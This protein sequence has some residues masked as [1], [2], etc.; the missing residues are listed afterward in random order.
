MRTVKAIQADPRVGEEVEI[1]EGRVEEVEPVSSRT[2][3][4]G[5]SQSPRS[6]GVLVADEIVAAKRATSCLLEPAIGDRVLV[7]RHGAEAF[8]LAVLERET[9]EATVRLGS[10]VSL[11]VD[12]RNRVEVV[13]AEELHLNARNVVS[14]SA[15]ELRVRADR[16]GVL[17]RTVEMVGRSLETSFDKVVGLS[18]VVETL[19]DDLRTTVKRS[20]RMVTELDQTRAAIIDTRAE[21][22]ISI[23]GE[24]TFVTARQIA[25]IDSGQVHIG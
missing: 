24:N 11:E 20:L 3:T 18:R 9:G 23:H 22:P 10:A 8:V 13:G 15:D 16:A 6:I 25:K 19:A 4:R 1:T 7:S 5:R 2:S 14:A 12:E 21:G 17:V